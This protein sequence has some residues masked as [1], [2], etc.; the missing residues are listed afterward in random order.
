MGQRGVVVA[1]DR[2]CKMP[3]EW[4]ER[5][6]Q[7]EMLEDVDE[8]GEPRFINLPWYTILIHADDIGMEG[9]TR[10]QTELNT[11]RFD[12]ANDD[13]PVEIKHPDVWKHFSRYDVRMKRYIPKEQEQKERL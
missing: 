10:Y 12:V 1:V 9:F 8:K 6:A 3:Q 13:D 7:P 11:L 4:L 5:N 2:K